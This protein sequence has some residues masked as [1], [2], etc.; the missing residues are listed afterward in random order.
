[1]ENLSEGAQ[2]VFL[3]QDEEMTQFLSMNVGKRLVAALQ[4]STEGDRD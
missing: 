2:H 4:E 3:R 1:M